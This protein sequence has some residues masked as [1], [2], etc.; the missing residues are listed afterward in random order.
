M[1]NLGVLKGGAMFNSIFTFKNVLS[2]VGLDNKRLANFVELVSQPGYC[3]SFFKQAI[4]AGYVSMPHP[5]EGSEIYC[6]QTVFYKKHTVQVSMVGCRA[7]RSLPT[8]WN[9]SP[10]YMPSTKIPPSR[11]P[12]L[13]RCCRPMLAMY[14]RGS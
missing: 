10:R 14:G 6:V 7:T 12:T 2:G 13:R 9:R 5:Y 3:L 4:K 1:A 11:A 8:S